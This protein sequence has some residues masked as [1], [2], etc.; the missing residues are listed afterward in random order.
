MV[1]GAGLEMSDKI[2]IY[3]TFNYINNPIAPPVAPV[4]VRKIL[5][6]NPH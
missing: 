1:P 5:D 4:P 6:L 3:K 2:L